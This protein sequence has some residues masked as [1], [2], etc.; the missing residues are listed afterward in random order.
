MC[1]KLNPALL[2]CSEARI[3]EEVN[4]IEYKMDGYNEIVCMSDVSFQTYWWN[5][6]LSKTILNTK[7]KTILNTK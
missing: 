3:T 1:N 5:S 4:E 7:Y 6:D 2:C